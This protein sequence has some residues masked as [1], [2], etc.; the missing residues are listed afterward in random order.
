MA[1]TDQDTYIE[2]HVVIAPTLA[3]LKLNQGGLATGN[4][5]LA[6]LIGNAAAFDQ[7]GL[8]YAWDPALTTAG[9]DTTIVQPTAIT[10]ASPGRW[11][12]V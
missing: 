3:N 5:A 4:Y 6:Y 9:N 1:Q 10:G 7:A 12:K 8:W 11:R 2:S